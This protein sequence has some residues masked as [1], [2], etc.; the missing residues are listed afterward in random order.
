[1]LTADGLVSAR[2]LGSVR[3]GRD[4]ARDQQEDDARS[5]VFETRHL[6]KRIEILGAPI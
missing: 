6:L 3:R 4:Q 2:V 5:L 1:M